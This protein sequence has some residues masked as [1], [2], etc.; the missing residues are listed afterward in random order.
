VVL[1]VWVTGS[2]I[3]VSQGLNIFWIIAKRLA[4]DRPRSGGRTLSRVTTQVTQ[5]RKGQAR[6]GWER[7]S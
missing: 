3:W 6:R 7:R 2:R 1:S 5:E 4:F